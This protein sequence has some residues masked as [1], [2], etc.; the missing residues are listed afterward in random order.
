[1][2]TRHGNKVKVIALVDPALYDKFKVQAE[3]DNRSVSN[4][5]ATLMEVYI[6]EKQ[7]GKK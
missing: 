2:P 5:V 4:L 1:M 7:R 3:V 6:Y